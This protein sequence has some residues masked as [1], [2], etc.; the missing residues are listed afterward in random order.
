M[1]FLETRTREPYFKTLIST[2]RSNTLSTFIH[3]SIK[4]TLTSDSGKIHTV[5]VD[6]VSTAINPKLA[7]Y[8]NTVHNMKP[9]AGLNSSQEQRVNLQWHCTP[10]ELF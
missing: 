2:L 10:F 4:G 1:Y 3:Y 9:C 6:L 7:S 8:R 5:L